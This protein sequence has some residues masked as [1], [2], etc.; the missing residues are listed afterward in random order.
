[1]YRLVL[2]AAVSAVTPVLVIGQTP[3]APGAESAPIPRLIAPP[4]P[5]RPFPDRGVLVVRLPPDAE[6]YFNWH[7]IKS[8][9]DTRIFV[10]PP[11]PLTHSY[12]YDLKVTVVRDARLYS[13][14]QRV[15]FRPGE[16]TPVFFGDV[17]PP[18]PHGYN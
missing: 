17:K 16:I 5:Q 12:F 11:L 7:Y 14:F 13:A 15:I 18:F 4:L 6:L 2:I 10:T 8:T 3:V 9:S 1:M